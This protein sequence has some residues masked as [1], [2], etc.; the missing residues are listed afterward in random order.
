MRLRID[1]E[2]NRTINFRQAP[3]FRPEKLILFA[4]SRRFWPFRKNSGLT[5]VEALVV[6]LLI[7]ILSGLAIRY[8]EKTGEHG[9][10]LEA[11]AALRRIADAEK[12]Y[13]LENGTYYP[14]CPTASPEVVET[15]R[16][17]INGN[18]SI[19]LSGT[20]WIYSIASSSGDN[21]R[22]YANRTGTGTYSGCVYSIN[23]SGTEPEKNSQCL[24]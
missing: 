18:L 2:V 20:D 10:G 22:A 14:L 1:G 15:D 4:Y 7:A 3:V 11:K 12:N 17:N 13:R 24:P 5:V 23:E 16:N 8:F 19:M 9:R 21:Y 6:M